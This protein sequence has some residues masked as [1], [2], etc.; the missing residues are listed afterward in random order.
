MVQTP[1]QELTWFPAPVRQVLDFERITP[2]PGADA[3]AVAHEFLARV[4]A[5]GPGVLEIGGIATVWDLLVD[6]AVVA[7]GHSMFERRIVE[8]GPGDHEVRIVVHPLT[9]L[10][11][12]LPTKPRQRW[13]TMLVEE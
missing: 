7:S 2:E 11:D 8:V 6:D 13:R 5:D 9:E 4:T 1:E 12:E 10:L 3:D